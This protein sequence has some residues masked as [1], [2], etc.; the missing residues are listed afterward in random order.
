MT[1]RYQTTLGTT[2]F[3]QRKRHEYTNNGH[4]ND[5]SVETKP[6]IKSKTLWLNYGAL[7]ATLFGA[8]AQVLPSLQGIFDLKTYLI[9]GAVVNIANVVLRKYF[10]ST[11]IGNA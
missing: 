4:T 1:A 9:V 7:A 10:T 5:M 11:P 2:C 8:V 6:D 3:T